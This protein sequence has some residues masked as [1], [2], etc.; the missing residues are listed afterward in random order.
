MRRVKQCLMNL[1]PRFNCTRMVEEYDTQMYEPAHRAF[2]EIE[3]DQYESSRRRVLWNHEVRRVWDQVRFVEMSAGADRSVLS[4]QPVTMR[5]IV[6]LAGLK[7]TDLKVEAVVGRVGAVGQ[8]ED[9][10][11]MTLAPTA[12][13]G[14][15]WEFSAKFIPTMTGRLGY[16]MRVSPNDQDDPL[17]RSC[18]SLMRWV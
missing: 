14:S 1:S 5:A 15:A 6:E 13:H 2:L 12:E 17:S 18:Y 3:R 7:P 4:G 11:V 10:Q 8:L 16:A 9:T